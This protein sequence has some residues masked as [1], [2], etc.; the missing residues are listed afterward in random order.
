MSVFAK[1]NEKVNK[2][3][4]AK[5]IAEAKENKGGADVPVGIY[6]VEVEKIE[7][8]ET[9]KGDPMISIWFNILDGNYKGCKLFHNLV[10]QPTSQYFGFQMHK[11]IEFIESLGTELELKDNTDLGAL[12]EWVNDVFE[13]IQ[14]NG[15]EYDLEFS[16]DK[17]DF[18]VYTIKEIFV[19]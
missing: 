6:E 2:E 5:D 15:L 3:Q 17:K 13:Y 9:K 8:K 10:I 14:D 12:E 11:A 4:L 19:D 18:A 1:F 7:C 16:K